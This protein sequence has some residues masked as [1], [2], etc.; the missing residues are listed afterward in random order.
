MSI[1]Y[2]RMDGSEFEYALFHPQM[3]EVVI[4][5]PQRAVLVRYHT[6]YDEDGNLAYREEYRDEDPS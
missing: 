4:L 2:K 1:I 5:D 6:V 3:R